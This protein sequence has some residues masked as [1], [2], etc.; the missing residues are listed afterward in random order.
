[1]TI[2]QIFKTIGEYAKD[3]REIK[4]L[5]NLFRYYIDCCNEHIKDEDCYM[6]K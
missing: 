3:R 4:H 1:M 2:K 5:D 6:W